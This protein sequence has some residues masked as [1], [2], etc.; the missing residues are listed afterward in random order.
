M[1]NE[2]AI[3]PSHTFNKRDK[4]QIIL[5]GNGLNQTKDGGSWSDLLKTIK[6]ADIEVDYDKLV[7]PMTLRTLL[8]TRDDNVSKKVSDYYM[9][10]VYCENSLLEKVLSLPCVDILT[11]NYSYELENT[12]Q[13]GISRYGIEKSMNSLK[14]QADQ[15]YLLSTFNQFMYQGQPK[16]IWHIHGEARKPT[17]IVLTHDAYGRLLSRYIDEIGQRGNK[18]KNLRDLGYFRYWSWLDYFILG[19]VYILGFG[20]DYSEND[21]WWLLIRKYRENAS[22]GKVYYYNYKE[23]DDQG[24][25]ITGEKHKILERIG[26]IVKTL[27]VTKV[28]GKDFN[29]IDFYEKAIKDI[30]EMMEQNK[31]L[32]L[33]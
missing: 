17:S 24:H 25:P 1:K 20:L 15:K 18:Y 16:R 2:K 10:K 7:S 21:L 12:I 26:C 27:D 13:P 14:Q 23:E 22:C 11:T 31:Q 32:E 29:Y 8:L 19:D 6:D 4:P 9:Q 33:I 30:E 3:C 5:L 28:Q